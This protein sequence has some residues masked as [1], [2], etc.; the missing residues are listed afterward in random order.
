VNQ[1]ISI[2]QILKS[3][4]L[5][6]AYIGAL[7]EGMAE[8]DYLDG[9]NVETLKKWLGEHFDS[10]LAAY[11]RQDAA[12][13]AYYRQQLEGASQ[14]VAV[15]IGWAGSGALAL[16]CLC[17]QE[18]KIPCQITGLIAGTNTVHNVEPYATERFR[19]TGK[20]VSYMYSPDTNRDL[21]K[22]H[23]LNKFY[24]VYWELLLSSTSPQF[25]AFDF[26]EKGNVTFVFGKTDPN[27][28][29]IREIRKGIL[30][31]ADA[32]REHF[33]DMPEML[34]ISGRDAYAP[35]LTAASK[36]EKYLKDIYRYFDINI[37]I[38]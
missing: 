32:Y 16:D 14:A 9:D 29:G 31:F 12:A 22:K 2:E 19:Q 28:E 15:D 5:D 21:F 4:E 3:M 13:R 38:G 18:W 6:K 11:E 26:D 1:S 27:P 20:L 17:R 24:N 36:D 34:A 33:T 8:T 10:I 35:M 30:D 37:G 7:P 23:D 25:R